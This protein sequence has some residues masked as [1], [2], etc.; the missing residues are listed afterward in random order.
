[1]RSRRAA[2]ARRA[3]AEARGRRLSAVAYFE[4]AERCV[5]LA[6]VRSLMDGLIRA[7]QLTIFRSRGTEVERH[8]ATK[9]V[10]VRTSTTYRELERLAPEWLDLYAESQT[11]NPFAN[12]VWQRAWMQHFT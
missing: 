12:P 4:H 9:G 1:M 5:G 7:E 2:G 10:S 8:N 6:E 11:R 3:V